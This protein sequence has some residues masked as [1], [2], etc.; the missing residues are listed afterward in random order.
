MYR[1]ENVFNN[2]S[3]VMCFCCRSNFFIKPS[4]SN[5]R[6]R[7]FYHFTLVMI[8][9]IHI[10]KQRLIKGIYEVRHWDGLRC[11]DTHTKIK[12]NCLG[13]QVIK[14]GIREMKT[15]WKSHKPTLGSLRKIVY[16]IIVW[17]LWHVCW[18]PELWIQRPPL[19]GN[20]SANTFVTRQWFS[21]RHVMATTD[22]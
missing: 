1:I 20:G 17:V 10:Q 8:G 7:T 18:K 5:K 6:R 3:I 15:A 19:L 12:K 14:G 11:Q 13:T 16:E 21:S 22:T 9:G 4:P 2:S